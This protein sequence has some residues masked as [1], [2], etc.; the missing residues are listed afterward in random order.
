VVVHEEV[1]ERHLFSP[2]S[3]CFNYHVPQ[4]ICHR[5]VGREGHQRRGRWI[6]VGSNKCQFDEII[7]PTIISI[8]REGEDEMQASI[9]DEMKRQGIN[10]RDEIQVYKWFGQKVEWGGMDVSRLVQVFHRAVKGI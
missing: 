4:E 8:V 3:C 5:W 1:N 7:M 2:Y 10:K 6:R 9:I